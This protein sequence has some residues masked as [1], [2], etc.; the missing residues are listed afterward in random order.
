MGGISEYWRQ[1]KEKGEYKYLGVL[2]GRST[3][4]TVF[5]KDRLRKARQMLG[6]MKNVANN[7]PV[8]TRGAVSLWQLAIKAR[9]LYG[10]G[11]IHCTKEWIKGVDTVQ[12]LAARWILET[13]RSAKGLAVRRFLGWLSMEDEVAK[14]KISWLVRVRNMGEERL[15]RMVLEEMEKPES[16]SN[17]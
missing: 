10:A 1:F 16:K 4:H 11:V 5:L 6:I 8:R 14:R 12:N 7:M 17:G 9:V 13:S 2:F 15:P 3:G